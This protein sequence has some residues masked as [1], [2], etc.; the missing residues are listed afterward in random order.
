M[1]DRVSPF[2]NL[3]LD[4]ED[5]FAVIAIHRPHVLN[6]LNRA[7][8][9]ELESAIDDI[10]R[11]S[12]VRAII[13]TGS[14]SK[15][16][17][18]GADIAE[19][20]LLGTAKDAY[21]YSLST[22]HLLLKLQRLDQAVIT[23]VNGYALGGGCELAMSG[24]IIIAAEN[25]RFGQPE[26]NLGLIPG[27][28]GTQRL[29]R[30]VGRTKALEM[31]LTGQH[32]DAHE[33]L[34]IGLVNRVVPAEDLLPTAKQM[35]RQIAE[36]APLAI[37]LAKRAV[38]EGLEMSPRDGNLAEPAYFGLSLATADSK[39]GTG[40]FLEKRQPIWQGR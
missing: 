5:G 24:D 9:F 15:A 40:A 26:V 3:L 4:R 28:G 39:E 6:A 11:D 14:G 22:H 32:I 29:P 25:A 35:A 36:K 16:F 2:E 18:A 7:T 38:Y 10:G 8:L 37:A 33:A 17:V 27:F 13:I 30:L 34:E 19:L 12:D 1:A 23:A 21:D 31:I 20:R